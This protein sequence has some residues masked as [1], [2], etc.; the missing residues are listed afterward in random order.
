M[1]K[2]NRK[3]QPQ[4]Q[5]IESFTFPQPEMIRLDNGIPVY[6]LESGTQDITKIEFLF[7]AGSWYEEKA[8]VSKFTNKMLKEGTKSFSAVQI[9]ET[10]DYYGAHLEASSDKDMGYVA[11]YSLNKHLD[12]LLPVFKE[13]ILEPVFPE[14]ELLT[15][16]QNKKQ[17]FLVNCEKVKYIARWKFNELI[18]GNNHPYGKFHDTNDFDQLTSQNLAEFHKKHYEIQNCK[19]IIAG[20]IPANLPKIINKYFGFLTGKNKAI[21]NKVFTAENGLNKLVHI[22]KDNAVQ[23]AIRIGKLMIN[24]T[25]PDYLK[26]KVVNT[27][28]GGYF[29]SRLMTTIREEKGYTYGIGSGISSFHHAGQFFIS[30]EVG[31][32]VTTDAIADIYNEI[33]ILQQNKVPTKELD[34]VRNYMLGSLLRSQ[35]GPFAL[36]ESLKNLIE[37]EM[38]I[39]YFKNFIEVIMNISADE[40]MTLAQ[41]YFQRET[42]FE[43]KVGQ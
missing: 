34:L 18:F 16:V 33:D 31:S 24:K 40:I 1:T 4:T 37:Y 7:G 38:D 11:L 14:R 28:L 25:H 12:K 29:G 5:F 36:S 15:R 32:D 13:V 41:Q 3:I 27:I 2:I 42:L 30:S 23:S 6:L 8:L 20:K 9:H 39:S 26:L 19:I 21:N 43:L 22:K 17:E 35:D 10:T